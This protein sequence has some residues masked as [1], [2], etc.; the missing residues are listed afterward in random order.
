[1]VVYYKKGLPE[2][3][4]EPW[5]LVTSLRGTPR[6]LTVL[7]GR[8]MGI[9]QSF[10]DKKNVNNG[11]GL[12]HMRLKTAPALDRLLLIL[13]IAYLLLCGLGLRALRLRH[14]REWCGNNRPGECGVFTIARRMLHDMQVTAEE[15][16]EE[17]GLSS[18]T[19]SP[20]WG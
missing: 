5:F 20:R 2:R 14:P 8:R 7:Y 1:M 12:R 3:R 19:L 10:R 16:L 6:Q 13:S 17:I 9:E 11:W 4:N 15:I 18:K